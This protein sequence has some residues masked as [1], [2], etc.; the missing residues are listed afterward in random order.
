L[1]SRIGDNRGAALEIHG[2]AKAVHCVNRDPPQDSSEDRL[3]AI[4]FKFE[5][6]HCR[7]IH[8]RT[9]LSVR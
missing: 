9:V 8:Y 3:A 5:R 1:A 2:P 4:P 6:F 7:I